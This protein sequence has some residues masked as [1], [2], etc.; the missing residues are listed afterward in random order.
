MMFSS[1]P[2]QNLHDIVFAGEVVE[3]VNEFKYLGLSL[4]NKLWLSSHINKVALNVSRITGLFSNLRNIIPC[5]VMMK[6]YY[7]LAYPHLINH[8]IVWGAAPVTHLK[9]L[10]KAYRI[11]L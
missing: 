5:S 10:S 2:T 9:V 8:I 6:L 11:V 7:A 1:R 4:T 3:W